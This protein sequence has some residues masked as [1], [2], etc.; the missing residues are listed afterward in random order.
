MLPLD[1]DLL[2]VI[3]DKMS[4]LTLE[5]KIYI[6]LGKFQYAPVSEMTLTDFILKD[7][8]EQTPILIS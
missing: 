3:I 2:P 5:L 8:S 4:F 7:H 6:H 1:P